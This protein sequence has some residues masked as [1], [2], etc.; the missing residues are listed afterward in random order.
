MHVKDLVISKSNLSWSGHARGYLKSASNDLYDI[1]SFFNKIKLGRKSVEHINNSSHNRINYLL[2]FRDL[3][4]PIIYSIRHAIELIIKGLGVS[5]DQ[6]Y[7]KT[8]NL[9]RLFGD[10]EP[11]IRSYVT[12]SYLKLFN[13]LI[14]K[15]FTYSFFTEIITLKSKNDTLNSFFRF[16]EDEGESIIN[17]EYFSKRI[18]TKDV[19]NF[20]KDIDKLKI[21]LNKLE[22]DPRVYKALEK[23]GIPRNE[24]LFT[25][26][27]N[28]I[29]KRLKIKK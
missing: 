24:I 12:P 27:K 28:D 14:K 20:L 19:K 25:L 29:F 23:L 8:H 7:L 11:K 17:I 1:Q 26:K 4:F 22:S 9:E 21:L 3:W 5:F 15:Y 6:Q 18:T 2:E 16:P 10:L 13:S